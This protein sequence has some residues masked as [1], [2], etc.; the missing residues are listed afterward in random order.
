M[1]L[2]VLYRAKLA[3]LAA[4][5]LVLIG[6]AICV[7]AAEDVA[8]QITSSWHWGFES[9]DTSKL[10]SHEGVH[11]DQHGPRPPH[12]PNFSDDNS[13]VLFDGAGSYLS[14]EDPGDQSTLDFTSGDAITLEAWVDPHDI[15]DGAHVYV[16]GKGRT[17]NKGFDPDNQN[18]AL[19]LKGSETKALPNFL[20]ATKTADKQTHWHRWTATSGFEIATGWHHVVVTYTFGDSSSLHCWVDGQRVAGEWDMDGATNDS[21]IADN[22]EVWIGSSM[23]GQGAASFVGM[24]D[25]ISLYRQPVDDVFVSKRYL[26]VGDALP[27]EL[28]QPELPNLDIRSDAVTLTIREGLPSHARWPLVKEYPQ[29]IRANGDTAAWSSPYFFLPRLPLRW[30]AHGVR[31]SYRAPV[32]IHLAAQVPLPAGTTH[33]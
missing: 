5:C 7:G 6:Q 10:K 30:D 24:I 33:L 23:R 16:V 21:P 25:D 31:D 12:F 26:R 29:P 4:T 11:R 2:R 13:A 17:G 15:G 14:L 8:L 19:R 27:S 1:T 18:W 32:L 9:E 28:P 3:A 22:D 20:F